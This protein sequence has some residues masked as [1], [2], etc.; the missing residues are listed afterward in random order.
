MEA[1]IFWALVSFMLKRAEPCGLDTTFS[2]INYIFASKISSARIKISE[3]SSISPQTIICQIKLV[4]QITLVEQRKKLFLKIFISNHC[5]AVLKFRKHFLAQAF[6]AS[7][8]LPNLQYIR[9]EHFLI[10]ASLH[11]FLQQ[12]TNVPH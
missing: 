4:M 10:F 7:N 11:I 8:D 2:G 6:K 12:L 1:F 5:A 9:A 3:S